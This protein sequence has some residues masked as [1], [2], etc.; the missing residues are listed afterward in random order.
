MQLTVCSTF[1]K[2][3]MN[4]CNYLYQ[5]HHEFSS[6]SLLAYQL[7][8]LVRELQKNFH[9]IWD[10]ISLGTRNNWFNFGRDVDLGL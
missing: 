6:V 5:G 8:V 7:E 10:G 9:E 3:I 2:Y 4:R 1:V